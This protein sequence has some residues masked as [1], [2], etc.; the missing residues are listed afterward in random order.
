MCVGLKKE[1]KRKQKTKQ[2]ILLKLGIG[3]GQKID[4]TIF[5][6]ITLREDT[7]KKSRCLEIGPLRV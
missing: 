3:L 1:T 2:N 5:C 7:H 6:V 4:R